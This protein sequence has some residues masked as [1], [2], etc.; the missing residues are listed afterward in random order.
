MWII[1]ILV[2]ILLC[3]GLNAA[4]NDCPTPLPNVKIIYDV[5]LWL[6]NVTFEPPIP[7]VQE[8]QGELKLYVPIAYWSCTPTLEL[9]YARAFMQ[10]TELRYAAKF[11]T[12][13]TSI[14][15]DTAKLIR[16]NADLSILT[17]HKDQLPEPPAYAGLRPHERRDEFLIYV[18][19]YIS[20]VHAAWIKV[21]SFVENLHV[22]PY[23]T[24]I[25]TNA[26]NVDVAEETKLF[27]VINAHFGRQSEIRMKVHHAP[28]F[29]A[30]HSAKYKILQ[31][32]GNGKT[33]PRTM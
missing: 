18:V 14:L 10:V 13:R 2:H 15:I 12:E 23:A 21:D 32:D 31:P 25:L 30:G 24:V 17:M 22:V 3:G 33:P 4:D 20:K 11:Y 6:N 7:T 29:D 9:S 1:L 26:E 5:Q 8:F 19:R 28:K 16:H 27:P